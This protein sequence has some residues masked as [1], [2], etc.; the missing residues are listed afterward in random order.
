MSTPA[1][2]S[3]AN[4]D[5]NKVSFGEIRLNAKGGKSVPIK[6]NNQNLQI[7]IPKSVYPMGVNIKENDNGTTYQ[8]SLTLKGCD[9]YGKE[10]AGADAGEHGILYNFL[11]DLQEKLV[12]TAAAQSVKWFSKAR[13]RD[14]LLDTMKQFI[15]P[16]VEK[17]DGA[18]VPSGKYPPSF[19]MKVPVYNGEVSMDVVG[20]DGK[21]IPVDVDNL[22]AVFPKRCEAS[23]VVTPSVYVSGQ[24]W[25]VTWRITYAR[26]SPPQRVSAAQ[27]F[28]DEI[29]QETP[30]LSNLPP[31]P[32]LAVRTNG[33]GIAPEDFGEEIPERHEESVTIPQMEEA[34]A[35]VPAPA[36]KTTNRRRAAAPS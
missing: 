28:A 16:S 17:V 24:G 34:P 22:A 32:F 10:R 27:V 4:L 33:G 21:A 11:T 14:V 9:P 36:P 19:R 12:Q 6:Y 26:V 31:P 5:I 20:S 7:R 35:P 25:G 30:G 1:I 8:M 2:V 29:D 23:L 18:W 3:V 13:S 15:S